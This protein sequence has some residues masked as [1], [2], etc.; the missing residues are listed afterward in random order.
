MKEMRSSA[1]GFPRTALEFPRTLAP[2]V[3]DSSPSPS[4]PGD[5]WGSAAADAD[6]MGTGLSRPAFLA[7]VAWAAA[8]WS[9]W[10]TA[11]PA[12][13]APTTVTTLGA[14]A[15]NPH[16]ARLCL[17]GGGGGGG[18]AAQ[19]HGVCFDRLDGD[20]MVAACGGRWCAELPVAAFG[21]RRGRGSSGG[22]LT[23][24]WAGPVHM[25]RAP[26]GPRSF[27]PRLPALSA[28]QKMRYGVDFIFACRADDDSA[29]ISRIPEALHEELIAGGVL[30]GFPTASRSGCA[31]SPT[32][33]DAAAPTLRVIT[34]DAGLTHLLG[35][36]QCVCKLR[37]VCRSESRAAQRCYRTTCVH[38]PS[39]AKRRP[40]SSR[41]TSRLS[42]S[43]TRA[44]TAV[45]CVLRTEQ[46][47]VCV[48][49]C[50]CA[51]VCEW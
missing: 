18:A 16:A 44:V 49:V 25:A 34:T 13:P 29:V 27:I 15:A 22:A 32:R 42:S 11:A 28:L 48:C 19:P 26:S 37:D 12:A 1:A 23:S 2:H 36:E 8:D 14:L 47:D 4:L 24:V 6:G 38:Q 45:S 20:E 3:T 43:P 41:A 17:G 9:S 7:G 10:A 33:A 39:A 21:T 51:C 31:K 5:S 30:S 46:P 35:T 40:R 50:A